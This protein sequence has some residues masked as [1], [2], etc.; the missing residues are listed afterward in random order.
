[1]REVGENWM[2]SFRVAD[3][4]VARQLAAA[5]SEH[6][7]TRVDGH[8]NSAGT[9]TVSAW[10]Y[11]PSRGIKAHAEMRRA[12]VAIARPFRGRPVGGASGGP[13]PARYGDY[14]I[15]LDRPGVQPPVPTLA[16]VVTPPKAHL[17]LGPQRAQARRPDLSGLD[18]IDW[19]HTRAAFD[20]AEQIPARVRRLAAVDAG[21]EVHDDWDPNSWEEDNPWSQAAFEVTELL[22]SSGTLWEAA[23]LTV[24]FLAEITRCS[25]DPEHRRDLVAW[26]FVFASQ[27]ADDLIIH[28]D[29]AAVEDRQPVAYRESQDTYD[30]VGVEVASLLAM[31]PSEPPAVR[32][33]LARLAALYPEQGQHLRAQVASLADT[34]PGTRHEV[35][36]HL[37][38]AM[39][40]GHYDRALELAELTGRW[41]TAWLNATWRDTPGVSDRTRAEYALGRSTSHE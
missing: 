7:F 24:P 26:L 20:E 11:G 35:I 13:P 10:S 19:A 16:P 17:L 9:W 27:V 22:M 2:I 28:A 23:A 12:A 3:E 41:K 8:L 33:Q 34:I 29:Y 36:L 38:L 40:D 37:V 31:W 21:D 32:F 39:L 15:M 14:P 1:M 18:D 30:A 25:R 6:G 5:L 4:T